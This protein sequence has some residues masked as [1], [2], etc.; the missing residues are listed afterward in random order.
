MPTRSDRKPSRSRE[1]ILSLLYATID[2]HGSHGN[3]GLQ[4]AESS[5]TSDSPHHNNITPHLERR[6]V[7]SCEF[8]RNKLNRQQAALS[9][10][11]SATAI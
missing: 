9:E 3:R 1:Q 5:R 2:S 10:A 8:D 6:G 4:V 11:L 7:R